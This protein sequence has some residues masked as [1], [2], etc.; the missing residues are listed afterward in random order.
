MGVELP[1]FELL[2][3]IP[4]WP[5]LFIKNVDVYYNKSNIKASPW[6]YRKLLWILRFFCSFYL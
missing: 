4:Y 1:F 5:E 3:C 2:V 6:F